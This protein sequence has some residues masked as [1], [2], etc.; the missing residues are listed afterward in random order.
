MTGA[1]R[2][3]KGYIVYQQYIAWLWKNINSVDN[4]EGP[5]FGLEDQLQVGF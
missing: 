1:C 4:P 3:D 2:H 5:M